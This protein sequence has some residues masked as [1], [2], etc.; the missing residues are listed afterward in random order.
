VTVDF[1][2]ATIFGGTKDELARSITRLI[3]PQLDAIAARSR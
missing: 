3:K 1:S 2:G